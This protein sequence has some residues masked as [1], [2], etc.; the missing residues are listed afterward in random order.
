VE[1]VGVAT[2]NPALTC[3]GPVE[4]LSSSVREPITPVIAVAPR[5]RRLPRPSGRALAWLA[6]D[7]LATAGCILL[8]LRA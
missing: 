1:G 5:R 8:L 6:A 7:A 4:A 3:G 2:Q